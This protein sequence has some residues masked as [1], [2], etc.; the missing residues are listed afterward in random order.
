MTDIMTVGTVCQILTEGCRKSM[1]DT[2]GCM[3]VGRV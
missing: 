2:E 3:T 1:T